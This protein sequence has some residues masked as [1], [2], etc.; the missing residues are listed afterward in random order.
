MG[1][2]FGEGL[3]WARRARGMTQ[4][5]LAGQIR[6]ARKPTTPS[7]ISRLEHGGLDP[8]LSTVRSIA[9]ALHMKPWQLLVGVQ[10]SDL[11]WRYYLDLNGAQKRDIQQHIRFLS[12]RQGR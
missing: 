8:K 11:F 12:E 9:R 4:A 1:N 5:E 7:Y 2:T 3:R 10:E 6:V